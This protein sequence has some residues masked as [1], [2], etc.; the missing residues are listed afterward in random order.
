M[1]FHTTR[2]YNPCIHKK[3]YRFVCTSHRRGAKK[4]NGDQ[5]ALYAPVS[6]YYGGKDGKGEKLV[7]NLTFFWIVV[8]APIAATTSK[9]KAIK[10]QRHLRLN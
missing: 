9:R 3:R 7:E 6:T 5:I 4:V 10:L 8:A 1:Q 2:I